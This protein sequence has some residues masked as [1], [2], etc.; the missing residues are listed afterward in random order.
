V[1]TPFFQELTLKQANKCLIIFLMIFFL[2]AY[3]LINGKD[4]GLKYAFDA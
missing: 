3:N 2:T 1:K 4:H